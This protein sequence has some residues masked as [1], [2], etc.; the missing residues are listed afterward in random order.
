MYKYTVP[1]VLLLSV[2][3]LAQQ[4]QNKSQPTSNPKSS[5]QTSDLK[6][7]TRAL[8][9]DYRK[10]A[11]AALSSIDDWKKKAAEVSNSTTYS[12]GS[13]YASRSSTE[14]EADAAE[15]AEKDVK[16]AKVDVTTP[17]DKFLQQRLETYLEAVKA[18]NYQFTHFGSK[19]S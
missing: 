13:V 12:N 1:F 4:P 9:K 2:I 11:I 6:V 10:S 8:S 18:F 15:K 14:R 16:T 5:E 7:S 19:A 3:S 17:A